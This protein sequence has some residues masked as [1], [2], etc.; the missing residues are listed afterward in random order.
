[1]RVSRAI[2]HAP[3]SSNIYDAYYAQQTGSGGIPVFVGTPYQR[4]HGLGNILAPLMRLATPLLKSQGK[5]LLKTG[6]KVA[7]DMLKGR[8]SLK[9]SLKKRAMQEFLGTPPPKK[10]VVVVKKKKRPKQRTRP[11]QDIYA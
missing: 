3:G 1:M 6:L 8:R 5:R 9:Q 11:Y 10:R 7:G 4:G 2:K